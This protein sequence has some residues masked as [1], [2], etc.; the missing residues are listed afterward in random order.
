MQT[1]KAS[2]KQSSLSG[3]ESA[4]GC[5]PKRLPGRPDEALGGEAR[6]P[7]EVAG[8]LGTPLG[9]AQRKRASPR[10]EA[11]TS[12]FFSVSDSDRRVPAV[13]QSCPTLHN[14]MDCNPPGSSVHGV[15]PAPPGFVPAL[16]GSRRVPSQIGD[17]REHNRDRPP[18][19]SERNLDLCS[20][21]L[22]HPGCAP[23]AFPLFRPE[24]QK[25]SC[26]PSCDPQKFPDTPGS[27]E[28]NTEGPGTASSE[29][30]LPS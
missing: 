15:R 8:P 22:P 29:P 24:G 21:G 28:G 7:V 9:L 25:R 26:Q 11:G 27:L 3:N 20:P 4:Q 30:L 14:P 13:A 6:D 10:G 2:R 17:P 19:H 23:G 5:I 12:G 16:P 18:T 1:A